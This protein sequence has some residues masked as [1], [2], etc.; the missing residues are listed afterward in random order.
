MF[1]LLR[2]GRLDWRQGTEQALQ[3]PVS[4]GWALV[5]AEAQVWHEEPVQKPAQEPASSA[6]TALDGGQE[7]ASEQALGAAVQ[8]R[9]GG[10]IP[11]QQPAPPAQTQSHK[12]ALAI[13]EGG[14]CLALCQCIASPMTLIVTPACLAV[15][16]QL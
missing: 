10:S 14:G 7:S 13:G 1:H 4:P 9:E 15:T 11:G 12:S 3:F 8:T 2:L 16:T 6:A 5:L